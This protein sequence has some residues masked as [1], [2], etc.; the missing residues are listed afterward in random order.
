ME[1]EAVKQ[2]WN[3]E[4]GLGKGTFILILQGALD[5]KLCLKICDDE[6][7]E[8]GFHTLARN[9]RWP[10]ATPGD[11]SPQHFHSLRV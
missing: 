4:Q 10:R 2:R 11:T 5:C 3:L 6:G 9:H 1:K 8:A 7:G